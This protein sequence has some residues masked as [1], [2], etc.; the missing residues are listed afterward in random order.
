MNKK[1]KKKIIENLKPF[2]KRYWKLE[3][4]FSEKVRKLEKEMN[5]KSGQKIKLEF[6]YCDGYC[7]GIGA[8]NY[9]DR[10]KFPLIHDTELET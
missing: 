7:C 4:R 6:F 9:S 1:A 8:E 2:W 10:R 5:R 3:S